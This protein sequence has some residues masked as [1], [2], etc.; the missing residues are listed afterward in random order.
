MCLPSCRKRWTWQYATGESYIP[1]RMQAAQL[2]SERSIHGSIGRGRSPSVSI[3]RSESRLSQPVSCTPRTW[4]GSTLFMRVP[5]FHAKKQLGLP[6]WF[7]ML[8][9]RLAL[10]GPALVPVRRNYDASTFPID[11]LAVDSIP[12][13]PNIMVNTRSRFVKQRQLTCS[14][15]SCAS[16][17]CIGNL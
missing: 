8:P 10:P 4:R 12:S 2:R 6:L 3:L 13:L 15:R 16:F 1:T 7:S 9:V 11:A 17:A 5:P 14:Y